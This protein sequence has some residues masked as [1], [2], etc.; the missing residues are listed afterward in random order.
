MYI[1]SGASL[2][3]LSS[4]LNSIAFRSLFL[5]FYQGGGI[6]GEMTIFALNNFPVP[7]TSI[8]EQKPFEALV[9]KVLSIKKQNLNADTSEL[10]AQIDKLVYKLYELTEEEIQMIEDFANSQKKAPKEP[11]PPKSLLEI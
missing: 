9:D 7:Q 5:K 1:M 4:V 3:F 11:K 10:E 8:D 6:E 2:K